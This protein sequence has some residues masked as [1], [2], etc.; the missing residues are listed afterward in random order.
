[1][2]SQNE[3]HLIVKSIRSI[4]RCTP[5]MNLYFNK[6]F[7]KSFTKRISVKSAANYRNARWN[8]SE[9]FNNM[10]GSYGNLH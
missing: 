4:N 7:N 3:N 8:L 6:S 9:N 5:A 10:Q 2:R 1:L